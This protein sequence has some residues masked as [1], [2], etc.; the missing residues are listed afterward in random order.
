MLISLKLNSN[1]MQNQQNQLAV[2]LMNLFD[3]SSYKEFGE[4]FFVNKPKMKGYY[5]I[6]KN[7]NKPKFCLIVNINPDFIYPS[8]MVEI[9]EFIFIVFSA[10]SL[11]EFIET[12]TDK[13]FE[14]LMNVIDDKLEKENTR[15]LPYGYYTDENGELKV[16]LKKASEV[17]R[18]Y[19]LYIDTKN[20]RAV[21]DEM[22]TNFSDIREILHDNE[23]YMQMQP[24]ILPLSKMKEVAEIMAGNVRGG[25]QAKRHIED[26]IKEVRARRRERQRN[27][28]QQV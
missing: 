19:D 18:I 27:M 3:P 6:F 4:G 17:R 24:K 9:N 21:A 14:I 26:E 28:Q 13:N 15:N 23:E 16:D 1:F 10:S 22:K 11:E 7:I 20:V 25:T 2:N 8:N 12:L 5:Y